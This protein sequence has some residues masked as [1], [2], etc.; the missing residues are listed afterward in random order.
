[1]KTSGYHVSLHAIKNSIKQVYKIEAPGFT[2]LILKVAAQNGAEGWRW[3]EG[4][5]EVY[6]R[7]EE[8]R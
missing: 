8:V 2:S 5:R 7:Q 6:S 4:E 3:E 1:M